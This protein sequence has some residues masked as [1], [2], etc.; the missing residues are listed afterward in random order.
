MMNRFRNLL[1]DGVLLAL[2]VGAAAYLLYRVINLLVALMAPVAH[3]LPAGRW[4]GVAAVEVAAVA[5][6]ILVLLALGALARSTSGQRI[7]AALEAVV[8][9]KLPGYMMVRSMAVDFAGGQGDSDMRPVLVSFDDNAALGFVVEESDTTGML[10]VFLPGAP[11]AGSGSVVLVPR[12][13]AQ[14]LDV[15]T[16]SARRAI[17]QRGLGL[18]ELARGAESV[19]GPSRH[20]PH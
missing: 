4:F 20:A 18:Q 16:A 7:A 3:L 14:T 13:R 11:N 8:L 19:R 10:T 15:P 2:P 9:G 5:M 17:K 12:E 6:L 1:V